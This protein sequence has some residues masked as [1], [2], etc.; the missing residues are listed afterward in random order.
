MGESKSESKPVTQAPELAW[1]FRVIE[2]VVEGIALYQVH[3]VFYRDET[4]REP[5]LIEEC[6]S[7]VVGID[8]L[9]LVQDI[10]LM[11]DSISMP[12]IRIKEWDIKE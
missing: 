3:R 12:T 2:R 11:L 1:N 8:H 5:V 7:T 6:P 10:E 9:S 4:R